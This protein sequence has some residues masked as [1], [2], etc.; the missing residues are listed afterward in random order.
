MNEIR[1]PTLDPKLGEAAV[2][3]LRRSSEAMAEVVCQGLAMT[4][5]QAE[6]AGRLMANTLASMLRA[7]P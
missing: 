7:K 6:A 2:A 3:N 5:E 1:I 4:R